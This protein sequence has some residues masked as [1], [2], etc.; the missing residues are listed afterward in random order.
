MYP[1][2]MELG[3]RK[4]DNEV[5]ITNQVCREKQVY[6]FFPA[7]FMQCGK[8]QSGNCYDTTSV[9]NPQNQKVLV[10][11]KMTGSING[12]LTAMIFLSL[13]KNQNTLDIPV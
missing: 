2:K 9:Y 1:Y 4:H 3:V 13:G 5:R 8:S 12:K 11:H 6:L 7:L 10:D